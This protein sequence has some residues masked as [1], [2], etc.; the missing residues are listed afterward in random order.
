MFNYRFKFTI[1]TPCDFPRIKFAVHDEGLITD[2]FIGEA[3]VNLKRT[4][5]KLDKEDSCEVP[6][7]YTQCFHPNMPDAERGIIMFSMT[8]LPLE[9]ALAEPVGEA[10][11]EPNENPFLKKPTAGRGLF[12]GIGGFEFPDLAWNPFGPLL[13]WILG[14]VILAVLIAAAYFLK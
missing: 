1:E 5:V 12:D 14:I 9:D 7:T 3:T 4:L 6:K 13:P 10:W 2:E 8:I 11:D